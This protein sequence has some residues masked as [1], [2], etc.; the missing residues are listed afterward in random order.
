MKGIQVTNC[1]DCPFCNSDNEYGTSCNH[2]ENDIDEFE[3]TQY[4][5]KEMPERCPLRTGPAIVYSDNQ[6]IL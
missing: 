6:K 4:D 1:H 5:K 2:P 3:M